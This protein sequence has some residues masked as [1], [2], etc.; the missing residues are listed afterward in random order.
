MEE[1]YVPAT[2]RGAQSAERATSEAKRLRGRTVKIKFGNK[3]V[4]QFSTPTTDYSDVPVTEEMKAA[5]KRRAAEQIK[6]WQEEKAAIKKQAQ[7]GMHS[8]A[9]NQFVQFPKIPDSS[10]ADDKKH[11]QD[12]EDESLSSVEKA[13]MQKTRQAIDKADWYYFNSGEYAGSEVDLPLLYKLQAL[14]KLKDEAFGGDDNLPKPGEVKSMDD[15]D[16]AADEM[17][18][19]IFKKGEAHVRSVLRDMM[20]LRLADQLLGHAQLNMEQQTK[21]AHK[22]FEKAR[23]KVNARGVFGEEVV[24][25]GKG[26]G[27]GRG[28]AKKRDPNDNN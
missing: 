5:A 23:T 20:R 26:K 27:R 13:E 17:T 11:Y 10:N 4:A 22:H 6:Q 12:K 25:P 9:T 19:A 7:E 3:D 24:S 1:G 14:R 21:A 16:K 8:T 15:M 2:V 18:D 28:R